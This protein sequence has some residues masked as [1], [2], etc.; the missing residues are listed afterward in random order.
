MFCPNCGTKNED[1]VAR[2]GQCGFDLKT[3]G[4]KGKFKGTVMMS[5]NPGESVPSPGATSPS[6]TSTGPAT[7][8]PKA[9][10]SSKLK[11]TMV[12]VAPPN[13]D[14]LAKATPSL[15][16]RQASTNPKLKGTMV[17]VAPPSFDPPKEPTTASHPSAIPADSMQGSKL[18]GTMI[19]LAP[20][21][22][23]AEIDAAR[24]K[25]AQQKE[26]AQAAAGAQNPPAVAPGLNSQPA[27]L[28][29]SHPPAVSKGPPSRLKGTMIGVAPPGMQAE[30]DA[31]KAKFLE[32]RGPAPVE[33]ANVGDS[34]PPS[35]PVNPLGG[36]MVGTSPFSPGGAYAD[37]YPGGEA[38]RNGSDFAENT[39]VA[40]MAQR[41]R[42]RISSL[43]DAPQPSFGGDARPYLPIGQD[44]DDPPGFAGL[45]KGGSSTG[46]LI[47]LIVLLLIAAAAVVGLLLMKSGEPEKSTEKP[48]S[49]D[50]QTQPAQP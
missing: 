44:E 11:G 22:M 8:T 23:Q 32:S 6:A 38:E 3:Q 48:I 1:S 25:V 33:P 47:L 24:A 50:A 14:E 28:S 26:A 30:I 40:D 9:H 21:N 43:P 27:H 31:A 45:P 39:P 34:G 10:L 46:P 16:Q 20:P 37:Q 7:G 36:T 19:G 49:G 15:A 17:G 13:I 4:G 42:A 2:C 5:G 18:K 12:G 29:A 35:P 41:E